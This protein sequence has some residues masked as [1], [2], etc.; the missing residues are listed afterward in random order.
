MHYDDW[1]MLQYTGKDANDNGYML[2]DQNDG[3]EKSTIYM[4]DSEE[5][6]HSVHFVQNHTRHTTLST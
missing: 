3:P 5:K 2:G 4:P 6:V 1:L